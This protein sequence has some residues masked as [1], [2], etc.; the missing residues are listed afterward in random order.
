MKKSFSLTAPGKEDARVRDK[1]RHEL[2]KYAKRERKKDVPEGYF[3]WDLNCRVGADEESA[4][5]MP[6]KDMAN[7]IDTIAATGAPKVFVEIEAVA[8]KRSAR[9]KES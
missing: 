3:R 8:L 6:F 2:N 5:A 1:I 7:T 4:T 9:T